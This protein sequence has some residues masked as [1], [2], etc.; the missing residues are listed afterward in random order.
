MDSSYDTIL[1]ELSPDDAAE[2]D[3]FVREKRLIAAIVHLRKVRSGLSLPDAEA[4]VNARLAALGI[5]LA[6]ALPTLVELREEVASLA[7]RPLAIEAVW[8]GDTVHNWFVIVVA[9]VPDAA[10]PRG[11]T[12]RR[13]APLVGTHG[14]PGAHATTLGGALARE[15]GVPFFFASPSKPDDQAPRWWD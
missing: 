14:D 2:L 15:L 10:S 3:R 7:Q 4:I 5:S 9:I 1:A 6:P 13:L 8:D 11:M 12:E